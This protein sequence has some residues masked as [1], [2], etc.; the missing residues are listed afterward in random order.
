MSLIF[1]LV[2]LGQQLQW[3]AEALLSPLLISPNSVGIYIAGTRLAPTIRAAATAL[4]MVLLP[5]FV[6]LSSNRDTAGNEVEDFFV[7]LVVFGFLST[8][9]LYC[10]AG[11]VVRLLY[12]SSFAPATAILQILS[13]NIG[14]M[15]LHWE[16]LNL[17]FARG[18]DRML[19]IAYGI[20]FIIRLALAYSLATAWAGF[21]LATAQIISDWIMAISL[22]ILALL[23]GHQNYQ[24][25]MA[26][27][28]FA[29][30][31]GLFV[32]FGTKQL[33]LPLSGLAALSSFAIILAVTKI[34]PNILLFA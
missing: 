7:W 5:K 8:V 1:G 33:T 14:A 6:H 22:H 9:V 15:L 12:P 25:M 29:Y 26:K 13:L 27:C 34:R 30:A 23:R 28:L 32:L 18:Q 3:S 24:W 10:S 31:I 16:A 19:I 11:I 2:N 17:L 20:L 21:G 4:N